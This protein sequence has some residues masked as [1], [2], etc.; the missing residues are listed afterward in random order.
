MGWPV[1]LGI[2]KQEPKYMQKGGCYLRMVSRITKTAIIVVSRLG[3]EQRF[4][5]KD[6]LPPG[7]F[8]RFNMRPDRLVNYESINAFADGEGGTYNS[9]WKKEEVKHGKP[10]EQSD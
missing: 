7:A 6:G 2:V 5:R 1:V 10:E 9:G 8:S 4:R 3:H